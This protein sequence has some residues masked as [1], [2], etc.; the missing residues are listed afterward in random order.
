MVFTNYGRSGATLMMAGSVNVPQFIAIGS[1]SGANL[2]A[3]GSLIAEV[4]G[5]RVGF[6]TRDISALQQTIFT[7]DL[8]SVQMSGVFLKEFGVGGSILKGVNDLWVRE[9]FPSITFDGTNELQVEV[10][11]QSY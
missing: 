11:F 9:G 5:S 10:T 6:T 8:N 7:F 3:L 1:G 2:A 4:L